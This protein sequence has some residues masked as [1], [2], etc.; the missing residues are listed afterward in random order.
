MTDIVDKSVRSRMM[1]GIRGKNTIPEILIRKALFNRGFR[2]R[3]HYSNLPG[4]PDIVF[5]KYKAIVL[6]NGCFWHGHSC[7]LFKWPK[8][9]PEFWE[10]KITGNIE[11]DRKRMLEYHQLGWRVF[12]VWECA[13]K[14]KLRQPLDQVID[15]IETWLRDGSADSEITG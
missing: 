4:K 5:S 15:I 7:H 11:R 3:I 1:S 6:I 12:I 8:T 9:R 2:Y 13:L 14:G 10:K